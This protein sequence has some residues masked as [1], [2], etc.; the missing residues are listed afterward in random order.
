MHLTKFAEWEAGF[1]FSEDGYE[2][3]DAIRKIGVKPCCCCVKALAKSQSGVYGVTVPRQYRQ[4]NGT[5]F[6]GV[7][8]QPKDITYA[9][10]IIHDHDIYTTKSK[11]LQEIAA[12]A[13]SDSDF[14][15][16]GCVPNGAG[17]TTGFA[18]LNEWA[19]GP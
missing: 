17:D 7:A 12:K 15:A 4:S 1:F 19:A 16:L 13:G 5:G 6:F 9:I 8:V 18:T 2:I 10:K 11:A 14:Y 3:C